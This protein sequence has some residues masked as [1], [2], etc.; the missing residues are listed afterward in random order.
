MANTFLKNLGLK[1]T[2]INYYEK[3]LTEKKLQALIKKMGVP[4]GKLLR[5]KEPIYRD[6]KLAKKDLS[7]KEL[8]KLMIKYPDLLQRPIVEKGDKAVLG[9]PTENLQALV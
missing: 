1:F 5:T 8:V 2:K 7:D 4:A 3:P 9:R 6:L